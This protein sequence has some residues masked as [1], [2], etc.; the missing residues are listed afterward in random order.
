[1]VV[2]GVPAG[3]RLCRRVATF[4]V[5]LLAVLNEAPVAAAATVPVAPIGVHSMLHATEPL[6]IKQAMFHEAAAI[7][8]SMIRVDIE[9]SAVFPAPGGPP[10]WSGVDQYM[11]LARRYRLRVLADLVATPWYL[12]DCPAGTPFASSYLCPPSDAR[13]WGQDAGSIAR[14]TRGAIDCFEIINEPDGSWA[15]LGTPQ[16]YAGI[17]ATSYQAIHAAD[18]TAKVA[19]GGL[20]DVGAGGAAWLSAVFATPGLDAIH[21]F[22]IANIHVRTPA[23]G[24]APTIARWRR[25]F[26][27]RHFDGPLWV[28]ETGYPAD[29]AWQTD[30]GYRDGAMSQAQ[31]MA[32]VIPAMLTAG[33]T[34]V[35]VTERDWL[36]GRYASEGVLRSTGSPTAADGYIPRPSFYAV[37]ALA[38]SVIRGR[39]EP[40]QKAS[41]RR[42]QRTGALIGDVGRVLRP[43]GRAQPG[44]EEAADLGA[45]LGERER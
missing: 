4:V 3:W 14:H 2:R 33:A 11:W 31:W 30:P 25:Y 1:M 15:F 17:L 38:R 45:Q 32:A 19:L 22:D 5:V 35:F 43:L 13:A 40:P 12:A 23:A 10:D 16:Q 28:T 44:T 29:A 9:L 21:S 7:G 36:T 6:D 20:M 39:L 37:R 26:A 8:A 27:R 42:R 24:A 34:V 41:V 18:P